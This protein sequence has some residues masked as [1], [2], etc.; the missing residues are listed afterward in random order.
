MNDTIQN[1]NLC[2]PMYISDGFHICSLWIIFSSL[3][4]S[5]VDVIR[6]GGWSPSVPIS[7]LGWLEDKNLKHAP[8]VRVPCPGEGWWRDLRLQL[9]CV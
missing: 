8:I 3:H 2:H 7:T 6:V 1:F 9:C 4:L 5:I